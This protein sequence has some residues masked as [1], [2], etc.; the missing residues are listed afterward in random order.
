VKLTE[1]GQA[2]KKAKQSEES[3]K[4]RSQEWKLEGLVRFTKQK[5]VRIYFSVL[6]EG[7]HIYGL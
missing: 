6:W 4:V 1:A 3:K 5:Q 7:L 2:R